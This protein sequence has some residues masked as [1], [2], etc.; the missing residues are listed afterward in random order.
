M[1]W[2]IHILIM[3]FVFTTQLSY[4]QGKYE[5]IDCPEATELLYSEINQYRSGYGLRK[6]M[7]HPEMERKS[8]EWN[9]YMVSQYINPKNNFYKHSIYGLDEYHYNSNEIIHCVYFNHKPSDYEMVMALMYGDLVNKDREAIGC[10]VD[11][12]GHDAVLRLRNA[13]YFGASVCLFKTDKW[14][15]I[16]GTVKIR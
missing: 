8:K 16:Y 6:L 3:T 15:V 12:P 14:W 5:T 11:S 1:K 7:N 4:S 10:W 13:E 9:E 2:A